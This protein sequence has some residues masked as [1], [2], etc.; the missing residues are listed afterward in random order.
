[1][2]YSSKP[3]PIASLLV[4]LLTSQ[5]SHGASITIK[6]IK[7]NQAVIEMNSPLEVGKTYNLETEALTLQTD[8]STQ[9]KSR[10]NAI[11]FGAQVNL[12]SGNKTLE[13][14]VLFTGRYGWNHSRF[15]FGP[16]VTLDISDTGFGTNTSYLIGGYYD[17]NYVENRNPRDLIYGP[18]AQF[19]LG[20]NNYS[21]GGSSQITQFQVGGFLTWFVNNSP[22]AL[23]TEIGY[24]YKKVTAAA[25]D[26]TLS[27][28]RGQLFFCYYY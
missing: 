1:M 15:E 4:L 17:Y 22:L 14:N 28:V 25:S 27:G 6:R 12:V 8:Y 19:A 21:G 5:L 7:G 16:T 26:T 23:K 13:N 9:Y 24:L 2:I 3:R 10:I 11:S 20:N 18:S